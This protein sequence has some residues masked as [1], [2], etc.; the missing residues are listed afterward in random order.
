MIRRVSIFGKVKHC[1][2]WVYKKHEAEVVVVV[3]GGYAGVDLVLN[4][5]ED[6][7]GVKSSAT[8]FLV[9]WGKTI[10]EGAD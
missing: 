7:G 2:L 4:A 9:Y 6:L 1:I 8:T 5:M 3:G 10:I